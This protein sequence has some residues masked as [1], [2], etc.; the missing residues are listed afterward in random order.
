MCLLPKAEM[1]RLD[2][3]A[4]MGITPRSSIWPYEAHHGIADGAEIICHMPKA[5]RA[6]SMPIF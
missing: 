3:A 1:K 4:A 5:S 6:V 2:V